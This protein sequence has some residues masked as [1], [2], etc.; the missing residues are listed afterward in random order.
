MVPKEDGFVPFPA[1]VSPRVL[2]V[3]DDWRA[4][5]LLRKILVT[6]GYDVISAMTLAEGLDQV[7]DGLDSVILDLGL[8]D[9]RG[10]AILEKVRTGNLPVRVVVATGELDPDRLRAVNDLRPDLLMAKPFDIPQL[11]R[12]LN[13]PPKRGGIYLLVHSLN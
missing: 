12:W 1:Q 11:L 8:P 5:Q 13:P 4:H 3:E 9:G 7:C 6:A 10:E 2:L